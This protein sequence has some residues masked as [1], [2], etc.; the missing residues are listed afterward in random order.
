MEIKTSQRRTTAVN[1][2]LSSQ[3][4]GKEAHNE[5]KRDLIFWE[6]WTWEILACSGTRWR[7][8]EQKADCYEFL[9]CDTLTCIPDFRET[10]G[11]GQSTREERWY[12]CRTFTRCAWCSKFI[13]TGPGENPKN[14]GSVAC[15]AL[16]MNQDEGL[17]LSMPWSQLVIF[18]F[19]ETRAEIALCI[20]LHLFTR[21]PGCEFFFTCK[22]CGSARDVKILQST[23]PHCVRPHLTFPTGK[24]AS[25]LHLPVCESVN[26]SQDI[27][28]THLCTI[29]HTMK[30]CTWLQDIKLIN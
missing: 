21:F 1:H 3:K 14:W 13:E 17:R 10:A 20:S 2:R 29:H 6:I 8:R 30:Y 16:H 7:S 5:D 23:I 4:S 15:N 9:G 28:H 19:R 12:T 27:T 22:V 24:V 18:F 25:C 11:R 26:H